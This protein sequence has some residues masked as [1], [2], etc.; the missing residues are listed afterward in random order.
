MTSFTRTGRK[1][2]T[3]KWMSKKDKLHTYLYHMPGEYTC[4]V[5]TSVWKVQ[6]AVRKHFEKEG[7][8]G[9]KCLRCGAIKYWY[10][11]PDPREPKERRGRQTYYDP[12]DYA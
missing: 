8:V 1:D 10:K 11:S 5:C 12:D 9:V 3:Y 7:A 6:K 2:T 4:P